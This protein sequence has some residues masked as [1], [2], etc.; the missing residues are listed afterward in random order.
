MKVNN[1]NQR[2][3]S[4][5][6]RLSSFLLC[7][8]ELTVSDISLIKQDV[9]L[10]KKTETE[11]FILKKHRHKA[12][13]NQQWDFFGQINEEGI[14]PF[15]LFPNGKKFI[16]DHAGLWTIAPFKDGEKLRY[17]YQQ[18]REKAVRALHCFHAAAQHIY[19]QAPVRRD[20]FPDRWI[21]RLNKFRMTEC[22][23]KEN[24]FKTLYQ[25]IIQ[26]T[27]YYLQKMERID[28]EQD[29]Q[30]AR[31][32]GCWQ[33]GD[34][35]AHNFIQGD[36]TYLIDFDLLACGAQLYDYIQLAQRFLP[37]IGWD[38]DELLRLRMVG[39]E[40]M[41]KWLTAVF[42][43]SDLIREWLFFLSHGSTAAVRQYLSQM[44]KAW[45]ER[46]V[47]LKKAQKMLKSM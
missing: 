31:K 44:E 15:Q 20:L 8:G 36:R 25:E 46:R 32:N 19:V 3:D 16:A 7:E 23:F 45:S 12:I 38:L 29:E 5:Q 30:K 27:Q 17:K 21:R 9:F 6:N 33:H 24:G 34:V 13:V 10:A 35:A 47:F 43:P 40:D 18:D 14:V 4:Y 26:V 28:W 37:Y 42:V 22:L 39:E 11:I 2:D 1:E 41:H